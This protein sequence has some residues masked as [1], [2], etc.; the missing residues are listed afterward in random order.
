MATKQVLPGLWRIPY[1][2]GPIP[3][4]TAYL[5]QD[6]D[7]LALVDTGIPGKARSVLS[8]LSKLRRQAA[9]VQ[10]ILI[11]HHHYD[12]TGNLTQLAERCGAT[13]HVHALDAPITRGDAPVPGPSTTGMQA[14]V[15]GSIASR[16]TPE[17]LP[18]CEIGHEV[19]DG[20]ELP[21]AGGIV[22][23]HTPGHTAGHTAFLW[24]RHGG[25][26]LAGDAAANM[27]PRL[28]PP[29]SVFTEDQAA[30]RRSVAKLA[31]YSFETAVFGHGRPIRRGA[32]D[33]FRR[34]AE[35]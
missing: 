9:D 19:Q 11:T 24:P 2:L 12:H 20:E 35:R 17:R 16:A 5:I 1:N 22:A 23:I 28:S 26:L 15:L 10:H 18:R 14:R 30:M 32:S 29:L 34:L 33:R 8:L 13:I 3:Y 7:E 25:V 4:T 21:I 6:G 31:G 27:G